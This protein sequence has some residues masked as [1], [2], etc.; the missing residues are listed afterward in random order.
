M[1]HKGKGPEDTCKRRPVGRRFRM[2]RVSRRFA[3]VDP[4]V[5][6][7]HVEWDSPSTK[8]HAFK[9]ARTAVSSPS[10]QAWPGCRAARSP[11]VAPRGPVT[12]PPGRCLAIEPL[13][14]RPSS[15]HEPP[16]CHRAA[17]SLPRYRAVA[18]QAAGP[19]VHTIK[20]VC[21]AKMHLSTR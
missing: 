20:A 7:L 2:Q 13:L 17:G 6:R 1:D 21:A 15:R 9:S 5:V 3:F 14:C 18:L 19:L 10:R 12:E 4:T 8:G 11:G 16:F